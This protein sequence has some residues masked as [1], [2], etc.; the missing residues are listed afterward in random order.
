MQAL[1]SF[2]T[3]FALYFSLLTLFRFPTA[4]VGTLKGVSKKN[5][6][7]WVSAQLLAYV[8]SF[9]VAVPKWFAGNLMIPACLIGS[10]AFVSG[11]ISKD[12]PL[13]FTGLTIMII[14]IRHIF[15]VIESRVM[16]KPVRSMTLAPD[17][18]VVQQDVQIGTW[19]ETMHL[20]QADIWIPGEGS[21]R[22]GVGVI[23]LHSGAWQAF[24]KG[25]T[26]REF[27]RGLAMRGHLILDLGYPLAPEATMIEIANAVKDAVIWLKN[28]AKAYRIDEGKIVLWGISGGGHLA[29]HQA[30]NASG[31]QDAVKAVIS[32]YGP[33]DLA[34]HS[35]EYGRMERGQPRKSDQ[36]TPAMQPRIFN[37]T[38]FDRLMTSAH[39]FPEYRYQNMPGGTLLLV[40]LMGGT[41]HET[42]EKYHR[43]SP[44]EHVSKDCPPTLQIWPAHDFYF[45]AVL[46]GRPLH[47][48]LTAAGVKSIY[49]ELPDTEHGFDHFLA[50]I[51]PA[52]YL[53]AKTIEA[54]LDEL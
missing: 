50:S 45:S 14:S 24:D 15:R 34:A 36:I 12:I 7:I 32:C 5:L 6:F 40:N 42:P 9:F 20:L 38:W 26:M 16:K 28:H 48:K 22:S 49:L 52:A 1:L 11:V 19:G 25:M 35:E 54:F 39:I 47:K 2:L 43:F 10:A 27:F 17:E 18:I 23:F 51:S 3:G 41:L 37:R 13:W 31:E 53:E 33:T 46:H 4:W 29:L 8:F 30:Y 44:I 21:Q